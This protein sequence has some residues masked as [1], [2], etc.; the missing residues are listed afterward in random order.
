MHFNR[1]DIPDK[2]A[3]FI[4]NLPTAILAKLLYIQQYYN[5]VLKNI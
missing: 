5:I 3:Y 4:R 2:N 1:V